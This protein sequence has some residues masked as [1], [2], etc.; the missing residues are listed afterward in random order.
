MPAPH[1]VNVQPHHREIPQ[2]SDNMSVRDL[3]AALEDFP[4]RKEGQCLLRIDRDVRGYL[5]RVLQALKRGPS[6]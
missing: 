3:I 4:L 6:S 5:V 2:L 1:Q